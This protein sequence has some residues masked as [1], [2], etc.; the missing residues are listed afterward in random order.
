MTEKLKRRYSLGKSLKLHIVPTLNTSM[1][2]DELFHP[3]Q[4]Q[5]QAPNNKIKSTHY[6]PWTFVPIVLLLQYKNVV[7]CFYTFNSIMQ[8]IPAI[9]TNSPMASLIPTI[10]IIL[11]GMGKEL[12][13][14][15]RRWRE[16][17]RI[18]EAAV[19]LVTGV[20]PD[21]RLK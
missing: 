18:N 6:T 10:F 7:V 16:D 5:Q 19:N 3:S 2:D 15:I 13:L 20:G 1:T 9:S 8:S 14:E 17:K 4:A 21:D 11:V 12:Y